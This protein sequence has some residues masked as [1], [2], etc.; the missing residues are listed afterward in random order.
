MQWEREKGKVWNST[1]NCQQYA[2]ALIEHFHW[3][4]PVEALV[5]GDSLPL[6]IDYALYFN[7]FVYSARNRLQ[8][9]DKR[10]L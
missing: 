8:E 5:I 7:T 2:R 4:W 10:L 9:K 1:N 3:T 6:I